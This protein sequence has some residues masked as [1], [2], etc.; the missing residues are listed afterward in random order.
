MTI[1]TISRRVGLAAALATMLLGSG[2][3][4]AEIKAKIGHAMPDTHPQAA[5]MNKFAELVATYTNGNVKVQAFHSAMLGSDEK[6]LQ[7]VK[8]EPRNCTSAR[9]RRCRAASRRSRSGICLSCSRMKRRSTAY[10][11]G[12][13]QKRSSIS[14]SRADLWVLPGPGWAFVTSRTAGAQSPRQTT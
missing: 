9:W 13:R 3:A 14:L 5:A 4:M 12:R 11:M 2:T 6:M 1:S 7:A 10:S 8:R